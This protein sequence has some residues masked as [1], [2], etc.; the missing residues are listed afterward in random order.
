MANTE[1]TNTSLVTTNQKDNNHISIWATKFKIPSFESDPWRWNKKWDKVLRTLSSR[2][3]YPAMGH[4]YKKDAWDASELL[5]HSR[6]LK[7]KVCET[8][9]VL[10]RAW[11]EMEKTKQFVTAWLLLEEGERKRH[12]LKGMEEACQ[13][14]SLRQDSRALCPEITISSML[15]QNGRA[16]VDFINAFRTEGKKDLRGGT[17]S[18]PSEWWDKAVEDVPQSVSDKLA[19]STFALLTL[20]RNEF[21]CESIG[22]YTYG[23]YFDKRTII[24]T[25]IIPPAHCHVRCARFSPWQRRDGSR[26]R[27]NED[28]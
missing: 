5:K 26:H 9:N 19:Q 2:E 15:K 3:V 20:Q 8:Q 10:V 7:D 18:L 1:P 13:H 23:E 22:L 25:S 6:K 28:R 27:V 24:S 21:I 12:L 17:Y 11:N 4:M 16:F 14:A